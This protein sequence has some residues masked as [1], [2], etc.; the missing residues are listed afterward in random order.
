M[1]TFIIQIIYK[2]PNSLLSQPLSFIHLL[3]YQVRH[4]QKL[5]IF[6]LIKQKLLCLLI[7]CSD[8]YR[9]YQLFNIEILTSTFIINGTYRSTRCRK[10]IFYILKH[11]IMY[12]YEL[13]QMDPDQGRRN[14]QQLHCKLFSVNPEQ[15]DSYSSVSSYSKDLRE[16][17]F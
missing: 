17:C 3:Y 8:I 13:L 11:N 15:K 10:Y 4:E 1:R 9:S 12:N 14:T 16:M 7:F 6:K 2:S 5:E